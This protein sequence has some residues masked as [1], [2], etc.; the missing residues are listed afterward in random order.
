[1]A[2]ILGKRGLLSDTDKKASLIRG[3][4]YVTFETCLDLSIGV[5]VVSHIQGSN[6]SVENYSRDLASFVSLKTL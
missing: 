6:I 3:F 1:M 5:K 2:N 4:D